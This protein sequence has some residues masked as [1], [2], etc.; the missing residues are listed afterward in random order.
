MRK[1]C[2]LWV[3]RWLDG[4]TDV[5]TDERMDGWIVSLKWMKHPCLVFTPLRTWI[6]FSVTCQNV[7]L[8]TSCIGV[9]CDKMWVSLK[10][11]YLFCFRNDS[12]CFVLKVVICIYILTNQRKFPRLFSVYAFA[13]VY[14]TVKNQINV[15]HATK[16]Q[17]ECPRPIAVTKTKKYERQ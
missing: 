15:K 5:R 17:D 3:G 4:R 16:L 6:V 13:V 14:V 2:C 10:K 7:F 8:L 1:M 11:N 12:L 9:I